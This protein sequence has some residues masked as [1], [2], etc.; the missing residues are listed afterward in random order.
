[1]AKQYTLS[2]IFKHEDTTRYYCNSEG[3]FNLLPYELIDLA[4]LEHSFN[5]DYAEYV[6]FRHMHEIAE[7][8][9]CLSLKRGFQI[10][11]R[12]NQN[13]LQDLEN[14]NLRKEYYES[15]FQHYVDDPDDKSLDSIFQ[16][17]HQAVEDNNWDF[18]YYL[19]Y[20]EENEL[21]NLINNHK[22]KIK[23]RK[24]FIVQ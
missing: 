6:V 4:A 10:N 20:R 7:Y 2:D 9:S 22:N 1:M 5:T 12:H 11:I 13:L 3:G 17:I 14:N 24:F 15:C 8:V 23:D 18:L 16:V 21:Y 19:Y